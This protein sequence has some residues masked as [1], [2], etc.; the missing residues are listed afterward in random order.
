MKLDLE[1]GLCVHVGACVCTWV[2][3]LWLCCVCVCACAHM[4]MFVHV[5]VWVH[6]YVNVCVC[7]LGGK[8]DG[9]HD[10]AS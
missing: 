6:V 1:Q 2:D 5:D 7:L 9:V 3:A 10:S 4:L 8:R